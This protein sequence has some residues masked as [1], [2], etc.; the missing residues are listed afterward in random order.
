MD[1]PPHKRQC[2]GVVESNDTTNTK[3]IQF[4]DDYNVWG[5]AVPTSMER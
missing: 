1:S 2:T 3:E 5:I 4:P